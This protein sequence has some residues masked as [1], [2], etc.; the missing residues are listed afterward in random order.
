MVRDAFSFAQAG[1]LP[2]E[3]RKPPRNAMKLIPFSGEIFCVTDCCVLN[4]AVDLV[5]ASPSAITAGS[6]RKHNVRHGYPDGCASWVIDLY[7]S[8]SIAATCPHILWPCEYL[9]SGN[10]IEALGTMATRR[11]SGSGNG[12]GEEQWQGKS[13]V[14]QGLGGVGSGSCAGSRSRGGQQGTTCGKL[15]HRWRGVFKG[16]G[17]Y[18]GRP[19]FLIGGKEARSFSLIPPRK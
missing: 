9:R 11:S 5:R 3:Q 12:R 1:L 10:I 19:G 13:M 6:R 7:A 18:G 2:I 15:R 14:H 8:G 16:F 17:R 4:V